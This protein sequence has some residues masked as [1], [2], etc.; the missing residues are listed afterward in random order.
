MKSCPACQHYNH[1]Q[2]EKAC[3]Q[4]KRYADI[5]R[6]SFKRHSIKIVPIPQ[7]LLESIPNQE[8][9]DM[10]DTLDFI[11]SKANDLPLRQTLVLFAYLKRHPDSEVG[12]AFGITERQVQRI[13][14]AGVAALRAVLGAGN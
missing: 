14:A 5:Q 11:M 7:N 3:L 12:E 1:G 9:D 10:S 2:G 4:C 6:A 13:R 8:A